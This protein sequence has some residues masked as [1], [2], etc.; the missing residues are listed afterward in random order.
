VVDLR[1]IR[2]RLA[3]LDLDWDA[4]A[5]AQ[6]E[7]ADASA[8]P[9]PAPRI[10]LGPLA[11]PPEPDRGLGAETVR[12]SGRDPGPSDTDRARSEGA[13]PRVRHVDPR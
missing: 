8:P 6:D 12:R 2:R 1:A 13:I 11:A 5:F 10:D 4:P 7:P 9:L 3:D